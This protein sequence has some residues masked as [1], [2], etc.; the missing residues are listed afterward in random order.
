MKRRSFLKLSTASLAASILPVSSDAVAT[1][2][3]AFAN[4]KFMMSLN[5]GAIGVKATLDELISYAADFRFEALSPPVSE[6]ANLSEAQRDA[7][8][9][10]MQQHNLRWGSAGLPVEFRKDHATYKAGLDALPETAAQLQKAGVARVNTWI[11]P[12]HDTLTYRENFVLHA[13]RLR[14][15]GKI[16]GD[17]GMR[18]GLEYVGPYTLRAKW[19]YTFVHS[20]KELRELLA[21]IHLPNVGVV[22]DSFHWFTAHESTADLLSLGNKDIVACDLNDAPEGR[23]IDEQIDGQRMLPV[24]TGVIDAKAFLQALVTIGYD[25]P[26]RAEPFNKA[27]NELPN[28]AAVAETSTAMH[29]AFNLL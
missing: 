3:H 11:M 29:Q 22:L 10:R 6:V 21:A 24:A 13:R 19:R 15:I 18:F 17:H 28:E 23:D 14:Q 9:E 26:V 2:S 12:R 1:A 4:R 8:L 27:L 5:P 20:L 25:G 16:L 7:V